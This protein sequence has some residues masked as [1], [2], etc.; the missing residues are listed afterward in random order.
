MMS[1]CAVYMFDQG[2]VK[3]KVIIHG[4]TLYDFL[5]FRSLTLEGLVTF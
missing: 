3:V 1:Q 5:Y 4:F 2:Q